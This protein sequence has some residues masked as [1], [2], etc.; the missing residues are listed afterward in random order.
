MGLER[1]NLLKKEIILSAIL[2]FSLF[3]F[4][5]FV[6]MKNYKRHK[7][8]LYKGFYKEI[9]AGIKINA[10]D[11]IHYPGFL[12]GYMIWGVSV[13]FHLILIVQ[14]ISLDYFIKVLLDFILPILVIY[15]LS[16]ISMSLIGQFVFIRMPDK[17]SRLKYRQIHAILLYFSFFAGNVYLK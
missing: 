10:I 2:T 9:P 12:V 4:Q 3:S 5:L 16:I 14:T 17:K 13:V 11:S 8:Q 1:I 15:L 7:L 6:T